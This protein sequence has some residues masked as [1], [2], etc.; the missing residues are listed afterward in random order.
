MKQMG[1][2]VYRT[3]V[4]PETNGCYNMEKPG[5]TKRQVSRITW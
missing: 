5:P 3:V 2:K 4:R 1:V